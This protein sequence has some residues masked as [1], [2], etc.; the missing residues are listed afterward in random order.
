M[1]RGNY[2]IEN[3]VYEKNIF[4]GEL[5]MKN[6]MHTSFNKKNQIASHVK[7]KFNKIRAEKLFP[8]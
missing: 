6:Y 7:L 8:F 3:E 5:L 1:F 2:Q 4:S